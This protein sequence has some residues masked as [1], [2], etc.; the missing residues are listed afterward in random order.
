MLF[1]GRNTRSLDSKGRLIL[2]PEFREILLSRSEDGKMVLTTYDDCVVGFPLPDWLELE[3]QLNRVKNPPRQLRDFRRL[4]VGGAEEM[5]CDA[6]GRVRLSK[7]HLAYAGIT[8]EA[9]LM[10]QG[11][12]FEL[13]QPERL[14]KVISGNFDDVAQSVEQSGFDFNF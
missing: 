13:W 3:S 9:I 8:G 11:A 7:D 4:V 1:R 5:T 6:Q 12:R 14:A 10:G 2:P